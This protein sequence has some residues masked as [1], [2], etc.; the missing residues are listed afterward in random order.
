MRILSA[1]DD[2][3]TAKFAREKFLMDGV[4]L[5]GIQGDSRR[6][7]ALTLNDG[8]APMKKMTAFAGIF[9]LFHSHL[10]WTQQLDSSAS[11]N[12]ILF[13]SSRAATGTSLE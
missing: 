5:R 12:T 11:A 2:T 9:P 13:A 4:N 8:G 3:G 1:K 10:A 6:S 7:S